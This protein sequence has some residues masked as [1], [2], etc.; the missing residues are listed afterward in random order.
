[1]LLFRNSRALRDLIALLVAGVLLTGLFGYFD[2]HEKFDAFLRSHEWWQFD[3]LLTAILVTGAMGFIFGL[4]RLQD[5]KREI[6]RRDQAER[7]VTWIASHDT[8][9]RLPNRTGLKFEVERLRAENK[10][11]QRYCAMTLDIDGF[12]HVNDVYGAELG[13][14]VLIAIADRLRE[15]FVG[16]HLFALGAD[17]FFAAAE[18]V[19]EREW[20]KLAR[21]AIKIVSAPLPAAGGVYEVRANVGMA[22]YPDD[23]VNISHLLRC[24]STA[25]TSAKQERSGEPKWFSPAMDEAVSRRIEMDRQLRL[26]LAAGDVRPYYQPMTDL[27]NGRIIGFEALARWRREDGSFVPPSEFIPVAEE[28][29]LI[30]DLSDS[31]FRQAC[32]EA[33]VW[34]SGIVLSFNISPVQLADRHLAEKI[35]NTLIETGLPAR[36]LELEVTE[37]V[38]VKDASLAAATLGQL[39]NAGIHVAIDDFGTGYSSLSQLSRLRFDKLKIDRS[40][41]ASFQDDERQAKI[42]RAMIGLGRGLGMKTIAEGIEEQSQAET[43]RLLGC[44]QGQGFLFGRAV[45][46]EQAVAMIEANLPPASNVAI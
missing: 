30:G 4:R 38:I 45:T 25:L 27:A 2:A 23:A 20:E 6:R 18:G 5:V 22:R 32:R 7:D 17:Q 24:T 33:S 43:L 9:T 40:F 8:L 12:R 37:S 34:P 42:V 46:A 11:G 10:I 16:Q 19:S 21:R 26:A 3:E 44:H 31:L 29:G 15:V 13:D 35:T 39:R 41:I 1:M 36:R 28:S 14:E